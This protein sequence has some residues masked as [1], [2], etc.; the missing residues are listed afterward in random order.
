MQDTQQLKE[1]LIK[2]TIL[3]TRH[4]IGS[5]TNSIVLLVCWLDFLQ[6]LCHFTHQA[7]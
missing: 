4:N 3:L 1:H 7:L 2:K 5:I 6:H